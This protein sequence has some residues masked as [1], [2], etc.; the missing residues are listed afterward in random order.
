MSQS[1]ETDYCIIGAGAVGLAFA[2][3]LLARDPDVDIVIIDRHGKP[4]GHWN[5]A[6][7]FVA[8]HQPSQFYGVNSLQLGSGRVDG[9]GYN[10]GYYE[11]ASGPEVS[12]YFDRVMQQ[13]LLPSGRVRYFPMSEFHW[14]ETG[15]GEAAFTALLS[16]ETR[17]VRWRKRLV[18]GTHYGTSVPST[19]KPRFDVAGGVRFMPPNGLPALWKTPGD[20]PAH[21]VIVGAGKTA[22][23]AGVWLLNSGADP[24][25]ISWVCP[26]T[27]W[28]L[29]R[30][31]T[32]PGL[33]FFEGTMGGQMALMNGLAEASDVDD[34]F[35]RL[36]EG[37]FMLRIHEDVW[38]TMFHYATMSLGEVEMLRTIGDVI[39]MGRVTALE[40]GRI[41]LEQ[42]VREV[43]ENTLFIDCTATAVTMR[44]V[45]PMYQGDRITL[46]MSRIPQPAF[47][48]ALTAFVETAFDDD[49]TRNRLNMPIPLPDSPAQY[50]AA[51]LGNMINQRN[52]MQDP[53]IRDWM[54]EARLDGFGKTAAMIDPGDK[55]KLGLLMQMRDAAMRA[56]A[57]I[58]KL[59]QQAEAA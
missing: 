58:P 3:E 4:G 15:V 57:N 26:R 20:M 43:P 46:Q 23:D 45:V 44:D 10:K 34:L 37:G 59:M 39:R 55:A 40:P 30:H 36:E 19:H 5:D 14:P 51:C 27:S 38:P 35:R 54:A 7:P 16:G 2:D 50:P 31:C 42:G 32:Q 47:C 12:A 53:K 13:V 1:L 29:N 9:A 18:D 17:A 28:L 48:A 41:V 49:V 24:D 25:R 33:E 21:Y 52:W 22:M 8:L 11:L 6:Y 56:A